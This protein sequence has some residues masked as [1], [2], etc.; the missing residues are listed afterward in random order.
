MI[1]ASCQS[2]GLPWCVAWEVEYTDEFGEWW[3]TID[4]QEQVRVRAAVAVLE[5]MGPALRRPFVDVIKQSRHAHMKELI[6]P[7]SNIRVLFAFNPL[8]NAILL[9]AGDKSNQWNTWYDA[10]V[11]L[12]DELYDLHIRELTEEGLL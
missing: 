10:H 6:P 7:A 2:P 11:P 8:R 5:T 9:I 3:L 4:D 12:A 1:F